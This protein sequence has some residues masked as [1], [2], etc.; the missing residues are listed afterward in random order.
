M[1]KK[2]RRPPYSFPGQSFHIAAFPAQMFS[3][4][5]PFQL[6]WRDVREPSM[7]VV[8]CHLPLRA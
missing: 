5:I 7:D 2:S 4:Y 1:K 3:A 8:S 6:E